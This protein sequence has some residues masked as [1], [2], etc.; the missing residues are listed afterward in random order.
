M[1]A[2]IL[3]KSQIAESGEIVALFSRE[4]GKMRVSA[5]SA[6]LAKSKL[7]FG[8]QPLFESDIEIASGRGMG[9]ITGVK[10]ID[11]HAGLRES[12]EGIVAGLLA[13]E[14][15]LKATPDEQPN[16]ALYDLLSDFL[17]YVASLS[18]RYMLNDSKAIWKFMMSALAVLGFG[19]DMQRC[20][21]CSSDI[22][23]NEPAQFSM[24]LGGVVCAT[25]AVHAAADSVMLSPEARDFFAQPANFTQIDE[26]SAAT[27]EIRRIAEGFSSYILERDLKASRFVV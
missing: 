27:A 2:I 11:A 1:L 4:F 3:K 19:A 10:I 22:A 18:A 12:A 23:A 6:K 7:A 9:V 5:R 17:K 24:R 15:I 14:F 21:I 13:A 8:L 25:C 16:T 20:V 26:H